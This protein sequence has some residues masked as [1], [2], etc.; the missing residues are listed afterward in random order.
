MIEF[1][2]SYYDRTTR[3]AFSMNIEC[4]SPSFVV[5]EVQRICNGK[6]VILSIYAPEFDEFYEFEGGDTCG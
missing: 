4:S 5:E 3:Q 2:V 6:A 1:I